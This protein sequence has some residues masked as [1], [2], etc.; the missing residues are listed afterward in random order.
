MKYVVSLKITLENK[1]M[2]HSYLIRK[3][4]L[5]KHVLL[6]VLISGSLYMYEHRKSS[7]VILFVNKIAYSLH[8]NFRY[9]ITSPCI[10]IVQRGRWPAGIFVIW[11]F[12]QI[13][14]TYARLLWNN[15]FMSKFTDLLPEV[16]SRLSKSQISYMRFYIYLI[17][18]PSHP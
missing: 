10:F 17:K 11:I 13:C 3:E 18:V 9:F 5:E 1:F 6:F 15:L 4:K 14:Y 7:V 2:N 16:I 8:T 12:V